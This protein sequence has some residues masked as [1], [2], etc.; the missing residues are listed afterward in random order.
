MRITGSE[1][2]YA[3]GMPGAGQDAQSEALIRQENEV[4]H[5]VDASFTERRPS[6]M[7]VY[8]V[9]GLALKWARQSGAAPACPRSQGLVLL[10]VSC[11]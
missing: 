4:H 5:A 2:G 11:H 8:L 3:E 7:Y 10:S 6:K 1:R 9:E